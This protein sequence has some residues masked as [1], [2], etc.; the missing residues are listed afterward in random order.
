MSSAII[1]TVEY[2][3]ADPRIIPTKEEFLLEQ[4]MLLQ[5]EMYNQPL[6]TVIHKN[7]RRTQKILKSRRKKPFYKLHAVVK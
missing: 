5:D 1:E 2:I 3:Y 4:K 6:N 7:R